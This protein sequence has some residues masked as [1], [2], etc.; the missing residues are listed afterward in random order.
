MLRYD[1][2]ELNK[3]LFDIHRITGYTISIWDTQLNQLTFQPHPMPTFC[4]LIKASP[5]GKRRCEESD[6]AVLKKCIETRS[7]QWHICHA[8][9]VDCALPLIHDGELISVIMFGQLIP[10]SNPQNDVVTILKNVETLQI[11]KEMLSK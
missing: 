2:E 3:L 6:K 11:D 4:A 1:I 10:Q 5:E 9:L 7:M 8:G